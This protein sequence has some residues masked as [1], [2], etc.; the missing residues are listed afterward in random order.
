MMTLGQLG[1]FDLTVPYE[2]LRRKRRLTGALRT[3]FFLGSVSSGS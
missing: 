3:E 1:F 2:A